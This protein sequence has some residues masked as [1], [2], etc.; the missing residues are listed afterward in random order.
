MTTSDQEAVGT[1]YTR[2]DTQ[3]S[4][5]MTRFHL[6]SVF[7]LIAFFF[8]YRRVARE[9]ASIPGLLKTAFLVEGLHTCHTFSLWQDPTAIFTFNSR[10]RA[11]IDAANWSFSQLRSRE[12][13]GPEMWSVQFRLWAVSP[14]NLRWD[15][16]D[17]VALGVDLEPTAPGAQ[18]HR[19]SVP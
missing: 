12:A 14:H 3:V 15:G 18:Q 13:S 4:C 2:T 8:A 7:G 1:G 10:V 11:H 16:L 9:S 6:R 19:K 17:P 5:V